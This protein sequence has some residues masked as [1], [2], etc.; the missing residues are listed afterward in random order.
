MEY[1]RWAAPIVPVVK[2]D[3]GDIGICGD[4]KQTVNAVAPCD[5]YPISRTMDTFATLRGGQKFS[6]VDLSH[7]YRQLELDEETVNTHRG[8]YRHTRLQFRVHN[9][10]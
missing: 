7:A 3:N 4:Y 10:T 9:A 8:L 2:N 1:S 6:K 5:S